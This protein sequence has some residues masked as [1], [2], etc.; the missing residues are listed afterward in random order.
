MEIPKMSAQSGVFGELG[1]KSSWSD[2]LLSG[3][4]QSSSVKLTIRFY[5]S[6]NVFGAG[7]SIAHQD[8]IVVHQGAKAG[9]NCRIHQGVTIGSGRAV[10]GDMVPS[11]G[12][13]VFIGPGA[14]ILGAITIADGIAIGAN[15]YVD[16]SFT[17]PDITIA[18]CPARKISDKSTEDLWIRA[19]DILRGQPKQI[20]RWLPSRENAN[21]S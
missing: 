4:V 9:E 2:F 12:N 3:A 6:P 16:K 1:E 20:T 18:G 15:S 14:V 11:I 7:L 17:E 19:T 5:N 21:V 10:P 8:A 13:N